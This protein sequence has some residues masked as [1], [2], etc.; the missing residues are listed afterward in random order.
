LLAPSQGWKVHCSPENS[1]KVDKDKKNQ[2]NDNLATCRGLLAF[3]GQWIIKIKTVHHLRSTDEI[4]KLR[5][6]E[7]SC[8]ESLTL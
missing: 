6:L 3:K 1:T 2:H 8:V 4:C 7:M 5:Y